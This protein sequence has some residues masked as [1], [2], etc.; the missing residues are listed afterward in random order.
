MDNSFI[1]SL[2]RQRKLTNLGAKADIIVSR[3][4]G[5]V[6]MYEEMEVVVR[7]ER[8]MVRKYQQ[9]EVKRLLDLQMGEFQG[10]PII[11]N[12]RRQYT[13]EF[14]GVLLRHIILLFRGGS[15]QG[16]TQKAKS[17]FGPLNTLLVNCQGLGT[18]LPD[19]SRVNDPDEDFKAICFDEA[20]Y[21]QVIS[22]KAVFQAGNDLVSLGQ[23]ACNQH[24]YT[25]WGYGMA[26]IL[27]SNDF[28]L[29]VEEGVEKEEDAEWLQA[30]IAVVELSDDQVWYK[31]SHKPKPVFHDR[32]GFQKKAR[33]AAGSFGGA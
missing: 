13:S 27:C 30:N 25:V 6:R 20:K 15:Q 33:L 22:N 32:H 21:Q 4:R 31:G 9:M 28:P 2:W 26:M 23:S 17:L 5:A 11:D 7:K 3:C 18:S 12:W 19:L 29:S 1:M 16:K 8:E 14:W 24:A 10:H